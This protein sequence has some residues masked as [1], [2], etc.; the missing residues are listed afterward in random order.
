MA[1][2]PLRAVLATLGI[3]LGVALV[4][5]IQIINGSTIGF[6]R[7]S[8]VSFA[9]NARLSVTGDDA[10]FPEEHLEKVRGVEGVANAAPTVEARVTFTT[11]D[12]TQRNLLVFGIDLLNDSAI[13]AWKTQDQDV[14]DDPLEFLNQPD[15][16]ILTHAF[17]K[18][19]GLR[20]ESPM[21]LMTAF[22]NKTFVVR[23]LLTP[24]GAAKAYGGGLAI[25]DIDGAR[26]M[27]GKEGR[28]DRIDIVPEENADLEAIAVALQNKLGP[29]YRV[30]RPEGQ[31]DAFDRMVQGYQSVLSFLSTLALLVG[32]LLVANTLAMSAA[33]RRQEIGLL[34]VVGASRRMLVGMV[35]G[36]A[37][38]LGF[39]GGVVGVGLGWL[40]AKALVGWVSGAMS[41]QYVTPIDVTTLSLRPAD[42]GVALGLGVGVALV[43]SV[44]P[45]LVTTRVP[46]M[47]ALRP[48]EVDH[49][50]KARKRTVMVRAVGLA[51][52]L[53]V[54]P[55]GAVSDVL[56]ARALLP[57]V[58]IA[59][60]VLGSP[61]LVEWMVRVSRG[62]VSSVGSTGMGTVVRL[63]CDSLLRNPRRTGANVIGLV[64][65]LLLVVVIAT[66]HRTFESTLVHQIDRSMPNSVLVTSMGRIVSLQVQPLHEDLGPQIG[67]VPGVLHQ[68]GVG[69]YGFRAVKTRYRGDEIALKAWDRPHPATRYE[70]FDM[71]DRPAAEA[72]PELFRPEAPAAMVSRNFVQ[73]FGLDTGDDL[74]LATP[75]G[76][77]TLRVVGVVNDLAAPNGTVFIDRALYKR[78]W[79][80]PLLTAFAVQ[81]AP[82]VSPDELRV[83]IDERLG[84]SKGILAVTTAGVRQQLREV[85]DESFA[86]TRAIELAAL[87]VGLLGLLNTGVVS[88][89]GRT[90]E[91][92]MLRAVGM[93]RR[94]LG[95]MVLTESLLQGLFG[96]IVAAVVGAAVSLFWLVHELTRTLGWVLDVEV[97]WS[98]LGWT[99]VAG[100]VVGCLAGL[101]AARRALGTSLRE[102]LSET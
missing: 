85:L 94:Q 53:A 72:G 56:W 45:A 84:A 2:R 101:V 50:P 22:G 69:A 88:V 79:K 86:Y 59:G 63:A 40:Q 74:T 97:P 102:A 30:E 12:G 75:E 10:G 41:R 100:I 48:V 87:L 42:A 64:V 90:R 8:V 52:L 20:V 1:R 71:S 89:L 81:V 92:G 82:D 62:L 91:L 46:C 31:V 39:V 93:T 54:L 70:V 98:S 26:V 16:I 58:A 18:E 66:L 19:H 15:S 68:D 38:L 95:A 57:V 65:G 23:G 6:F 80:D 67:A 17:A 34:R 11:K 25:M 28:T 99:V 21:E 55:A 33:E 37:V 35:A 4:I 51:M 47:D 49:E 27:F 24:E 43:A 61:L 9:G 73:R 5:A 36:E 76:E 29:G 14:V 13:R 7:E 3:A 96:G 77:L 44:W 60:A 32:M 78:V 83:R